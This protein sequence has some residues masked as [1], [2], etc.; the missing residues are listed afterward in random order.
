MLIELNYP[1]PVPIQLDPSKMLL[2]IVDSYYVYVPVDCT[3]Q[4]EEE[5]KL[6]AFSLF[7]QLCLS[8]QRNCHTIRFDPV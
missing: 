1:D 3:G 5:E 2:L 7:N 8:L 4:R 6:Q